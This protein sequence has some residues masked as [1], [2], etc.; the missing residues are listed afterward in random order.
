MIKGYAFLAE[1]FEEVEA[2]AVVDVLL[3]A[4]INIEMVSVSDGLSVR[5][6]H[7]IEVTARHIL[8]EGI[9]PDVDF[10]FLPGGMPGT[11]NLGNS[12]PLK[13]Q[14]ATAYNKGRHIAAICAAPSVLGNLGLLKGK[15]A[16]CYP[17][18][19]HELEGAKVVSKKVV[20]DGNIT[21]GRGMG[22]AIDMGLELVKI[23][24]GKDKMQEV[25]ES[26]QYSN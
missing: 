15:K 26:I 14:L 12:A 18:Y 23:F 13:E 2:I 20:T 8:K 3:R 6:A 10:L 4:G 21:T 7:G 5:G 19:E 16:T 9:D 1:G 17:G 24:V 25:A 22:T 11:I